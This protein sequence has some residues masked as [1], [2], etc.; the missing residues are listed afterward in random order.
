[1]KTI[2]PQLTPFEPTDDEIRDYARRL[3]EQSGCVRGRDLENWLEARDGLREQM[4]P[5]R[6]AKRAGSRAG[7]LVA[8]Y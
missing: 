7:K 5:V 1:M 2:M 3:Y 6:P 8:Q 4:Q